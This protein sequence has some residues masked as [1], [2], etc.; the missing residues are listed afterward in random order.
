MG[1]EE[2]LYEER[3]DVA[4]LTLNR[5]AAR[6]ALTHTTYAELEEA[7]RTTR[8]RCL[9]V[10][11]ADPAFCSG[12]DVKQVMVAAGERVA[13]GLKREPRLTPAADALLHTDVPVVAAVNGAAVG[14]GMELALMADIRVAS[15]NA[16]FGELFVKRGLCCDVPG[17]VR[18]ADAVGREAAAEL[19]FTGRIVDAAEAERLRLVSRVVPHQELLPTA[20]RIAEEIAANPPLAVQRLKA[21]L[22]QAR[23]PDWNELGRW[24]SSSL[25]EL[26]ATEDH[27]E[28]VAAFLEKREPRYVGR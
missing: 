11:G 17:L 3:G 23:D 9:V 5:P 18:L 28:G 12:D 1:Y 4:V 24:V 22:R 26:F 14:W 10:T 20:T 8:A 27:K 13:S 25:A 2:I 15:E 6:N 21:G 16:R 19:L 7:V